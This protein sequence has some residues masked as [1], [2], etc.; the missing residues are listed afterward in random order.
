MLQVERKK[1]NYESEVK[2]LLLH[3]TVSKE[4]KGERNDEK[5]NARRIATQ[6]KRRMR[7]ADKKKIMKREAPP[8]GRPW[9]RNS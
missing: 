9:K 8:N 2:Q 6:F 3:K 4:R 7:I 1:K 5:Y